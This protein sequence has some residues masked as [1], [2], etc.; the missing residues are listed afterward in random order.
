MLINFH[1]IS[2]HAVMNYPRAASDPGPLR[3]DPVWH[4]TVPAFPKRAVVRPIPP[5][6]T[7]TSTSQQVPR[8]T[9]RSRIEIFRPYATHGAYFP[10]PVTHSTRQPRRRFC[11]VR[12]IMAPVDGIIWALQ[13]WGRPSD[14]TI[15]CVKVTYWIAVIMGG[16]ISTIITLAPF[17]N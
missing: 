5:F 2:S 11:F 10:A 17:V 14:N 12:I 4:Q 16:I 13:R 1:C 6:N 7:S 9:E 8:D 3:L 15:R